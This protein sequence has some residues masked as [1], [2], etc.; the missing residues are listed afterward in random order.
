[1]AV[2]RKKTVQK[3]AEYLKKTENAELTAG[4]ILQRLVLYSK[5]SPSST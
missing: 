4:R 1:M 3:E 2:E 5:H